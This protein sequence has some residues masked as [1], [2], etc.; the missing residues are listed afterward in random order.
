MRPYRPGWSAAA[1]TGGAFTGGDHPPLASTAAAVHIPGMFDAA[2]RRLI[3]PP[4]N[5]AGK[6]LF[7][8]GVTPDAVT[9]AG[10][11]LGLGAGLVI[12]AGA[13]MI[14]LIP[15]LLSRL[16]DGLDGAVARAGRPT[17]F[18]G[19]LDIT[20]DFIFYG[21]IPFAFAVMDPGANALAAAFLI[22]SFYA[23][24]AAYLAF[25]AT[26][27]RRGMVSKARG[28]KTLYAVGGL[29]EGAETIALFILLCLAPG[30]FAPLAWGFGALC[31]VSAAA[32]MLLAARVFRD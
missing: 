32:R 30:W 5:R 8:L 13:P 3:D 10:L 12:A 20:A 19:I 31:F 1:Y 6:T 25:A 28:V 23:N 15:L 26:A 21:A 27:E 22:F 9:L 7:D 4:L 11:A 29:L 2:F 24:G 14:A 18:G 16:A 17:D